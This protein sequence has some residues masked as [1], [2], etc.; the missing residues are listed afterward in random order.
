MALSVRVGG[1]SRPDN[2]WPVRSG[3][4]V[5]GDEPFPQVQGGG[6][7]QPLQFALAPSVDAESRRSQS[8]AGQFAGLLHPISELSFVDL[9]VLVD[10]EV[11]HFLLLGLDRGG[12]GRSDVPRTKATLM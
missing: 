8:F 7:R 10:M 2:R 11:T 6:L 1:V 5:L 12:T 9:V 4:A 3:E